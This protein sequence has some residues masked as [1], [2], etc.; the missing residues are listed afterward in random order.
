MTRDIS[1]DLQR[2]QLFL[3]EPHRC[4]YLPQQEATTAFVDPTAA[5]TQSVYS[6]LSEIGFRRSGRYIYTPR[7]EFCQACIATR[8]PSS[9]FSPS[10]QQKRCARRNQDLDIRVV[11]V[12]DYDEHYPLYENYISQRHSDGDMYP[13]SRGQYN[14][15]IGGLPEYGRIIEYRHQG[16]LIA[17]AVVDLLDNGISAIYT[18]FDPKESHRSLGTFA[19]LSQ[20]EL[21]RS[22][23]LEYL[24]LGY[25]IKQCHKMSYKAKF[26]PLE[27]FIK[28]GWQLIN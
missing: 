4:S 2:L 5:I 12:V 18:Y 22:L 14:D 19:I 21:A 16:V 6:G 28:N 26:R 8:I 27:M 9:I 10:R 1:P 20:I 3:T 25:W 17:A 13:P 7:C 15:F 23:Q 24:Y 11:N